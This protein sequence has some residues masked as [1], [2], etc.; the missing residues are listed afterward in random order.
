MK[1]KFLF[2][3]SIILILIIII[4]NTLMGKQDNYRLKVSAIGDISDYCQYTILLSIGTTL[5][6]KIKK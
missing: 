2:N 5:Q 6:Y 3:F 4:N 1:S